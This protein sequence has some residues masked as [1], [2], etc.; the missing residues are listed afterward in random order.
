MPPE[1]WSYVA[2]GAG[3]EH[4]QRAN[5][6]PFERWGLVPR[7]LAGAAERDLSVELFG[8]RLQT[9]LLLA[10]V[11]VIALC[12]P[13]GH[14]DLV[15]TRAAAASGVPMVAST[16]MEEPME[17][18]AAASATASDGSSCTHRTTET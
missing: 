15:T 13:D 16:L 1:M 4:T 6:A 8:T 7:V 9:P 3:D 11:G 12:D 14:G 10:P 18:V 2:G 5:V 17:D